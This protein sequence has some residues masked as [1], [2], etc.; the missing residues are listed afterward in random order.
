MT[1]P[2]FASMPLAPARSE[3][4]LPYGVRRQSREAA[5]T[6]LSIAPVRN[7]LPRSKRK[8]CR[9]PC[10]TLPPHSKGFAFSRRLAQTGPNGMSRRPSPV[11]G[12]E[13]MSLDTYSRKHGANLVTSDT[14]RWSWLW[15]FAG[16]N[17]S[18]PARLPA[19]PLIPA[20]IAAYYL[21][22]R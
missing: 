16:F 12:D 4:G 18:W 2:V 13:T 15:P 6:P 9:R 10:G 7:I 19:A 17:T 8:R 5:P 14:S 22:V 3:N 20:A 21:T 11:N 1:T